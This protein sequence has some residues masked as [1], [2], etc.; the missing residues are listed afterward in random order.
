M[1][2]MQSGLNGTHLVHKSLTLNCLYIAFTT[3]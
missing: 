1:S 2:K 3:C